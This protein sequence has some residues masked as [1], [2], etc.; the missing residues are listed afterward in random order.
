MSDYLEPFSKYLRGLDR[1]EHTVAAYAGDVAAFF[2]WLAEHLGHDAE[3]IEVTF[4]D[5]KKYRE[6]LRDGGRKPAGINRRLAS[7]RTFFNWAVEQHLATTN[8]AQTLQGVKQDRRVPKALSSQE[9]YRLQRTAAGQRQLAAARAGEAATPAVIAAWR[10]EALLNL[11]LYTGLRVGEAASLRLDDVVLNGKAAKVI[12]RSGKGLK[13]REVPLH[14]EARQAVAAYMQVRPA[15]QGDHLFLGQR[16]PLGSRGI[17]MQL[18]ALGQAAGVTVTP[19]MLR[20]T[21][22]TRLLRE[23]G[24]DLVTV[25]ALLGHASI[26]TTQ[27]YTQPGEADMIR[28]VDKLG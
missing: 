21:F 12:V 24:A 17:Q 13:Y 8:P 19:H 14:K 26:A 10:D 2:A 15:D 5:V 22:A 18:A 16:G 6:Q 3:P 27:I 11:L 4:F 9:V 23:S 7:L 20:H 28:A 1:S 25:A